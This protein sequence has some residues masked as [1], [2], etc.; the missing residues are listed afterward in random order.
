ML[1]CEKNCAK[2]ATVNLC[3]DCGM[4]FFKVNEWAAHLLNRPE[5]CQPNV[6]TL[7]RM[8]HAP[9]DTTKTPYHDL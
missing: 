4:A 8:G 2:H 3:D 9:T 5:A 7:A 1:S 6:D